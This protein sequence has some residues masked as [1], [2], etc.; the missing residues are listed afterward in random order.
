MA[1][2]VKINGVSYSSVPHVEIPLQTGSGTA[3]FY[4]NSS[5]TATEADVISGKTFGTASGIKTGTASVPTVSQD[6]ST[7]VLSIS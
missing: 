1:Q 5:V 3:K 7:K 6:G 2:N 4:D